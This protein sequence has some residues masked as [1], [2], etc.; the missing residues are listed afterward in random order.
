[1]SVKLDEGLSVAILREVGIS[2]CD[3]HGVYFKKNP[4]NSDIALAV[5]R[6]K[7]VPVPKTKLHIYRLL[8]SLIGG[9]TY[10]PPMIVPKVKRV[11]KTKPFKQFK[12]NKN[13]ATNSFYDS[14]AWK[15]LRYKALAHNG[16]ACQCCG[17][18]YKEHKVVIHVDHI[19]P[20]SKFPELELE[21]SNLQILC[22][23]CNLGKSNKGSIDWRESP[24]ERIEETTIKR[25]VLIRRRVK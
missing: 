1:M 15:A 23:D 25:T 14:D 2:F 6:I 10:T 12:K 4:K 8:C 19:K 24:I 9:Q 18:T 3:A 17:R 7:N 20:R 22:A 16:A 13:V 5:S 11:A 21:L